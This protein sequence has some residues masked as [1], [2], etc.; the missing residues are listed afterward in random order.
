VKYARRTDANHSAIAETF[1]RLGCKVHHT[2]G[3]W[4]ITVTRMGVVKLCEI[5]D[6]NKPPSA[7]KLTKR[8][9]KLLDEGWPIRRVE[10]MDDCL[11]V[12][13]EIYAE[14]IHKAG[15]T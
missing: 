7:T 8:A 3:D 14:A 4:D 11:A 15:M 9:Q 10:N 6:P 2:I 1:E 13:A 5:K 12:V